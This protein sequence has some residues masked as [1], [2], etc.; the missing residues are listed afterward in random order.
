MSESRKPV[1]GYS[2]CQNMVLA[3][4]DEVQHLRLLQRRRGHEGEFTTP[5]E[6]LSRACSQLQ[7]EIR[8]TGDD[9]DK[10]VNNL[11]PERQVQLILKMIREMSPEHRVAV[12]VYCE[13]LGGKLL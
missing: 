7:S 8:K 3:L 5:C 6:K 1:T 4:D 12:Q 10:A 11:P 2:V 9:A 13:E